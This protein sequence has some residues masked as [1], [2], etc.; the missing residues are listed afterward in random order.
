[1][2]FYSMARWLPP[3]EAAHLRDAFG[4]AM[5]R[6]YEL[7]DQE[8][9]EVCG[10]GRPVRPAEEGTLSVNVPN[11]LGTPQLGMMQ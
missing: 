6:L 3:D 4:T 10:R 9:P 2:R 7:A 5:D 11:N 8:R 1:M